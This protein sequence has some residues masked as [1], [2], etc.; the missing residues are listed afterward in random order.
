VIPHVEPDRLR[1]ASTRYPNDIEPFVELP[2]DFSSTARRLA[3]EVTSSAPTAYDKA[4]ALQDWFRGGD[5]TYSTSVEPGSTGN[6]ID[7]FLET[8]VGYCEQ[9]AGTFAAM[10]RS[11]GIPAR[12]AV[13]YTWGE[14]DP[15]VPDRYQVLGRNAHAWPEVYLGQ[16]GWLAFEPTPGRGNPTAESWTDLPESQDSNATTIDSTTTTTVTEGGATT[17]TEVL[18]GV[19]SATP[20]SDSLLAPDDGWLG[21]ALAGL[22]AVVV[23]GLY[24]LAVPGA[25]ALRRHRRRARAADSPSAHVGVAW[26]DAVESLASAGV[27]ARTDETHAE[28]AQRAALA[29]PAG[30]DAMRELARMADAAAYGPPATGPDADA[31]DAVARQVTLAVDDVLGPRG[32]LRRFL[33][34]R[35]LWRHR[36]RRHRAG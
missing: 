4:L 15:T 3:E 33:D 17:S 23:A 12:V 20:R 30:A 34:P 10:A 2:V 36:H 7:D 1:A 35:P 5:F 25:L 29:V 14:P 18:P 19:E 13:G 11:L 6:P 26:S 28:L 9:F 22:V 24:L 32:R 16:Y 8:R 31:A 21:S 27:V